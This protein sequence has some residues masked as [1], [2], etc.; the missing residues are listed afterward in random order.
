MTLFLSPLDKNTGAMFICYPYAYHEKLKNTFIE[1]ASYQTYC[2][3]EPDRYQTA[4]SRLLS[5]PNTRSRT[6]STISP[7]WNKQENNQGPPYCDFTENIIKDPAKHRQRKSITYAPGYPVCPQPRHDP[8][9]YRYPLETQ[10]LVPNLQKFNKHFTKSL[11]RTQ[12]QGKITL[13]ENGDISQMYTALDHGSILASLNWLR[14]LNLRFRRRC[15]VVIPKDPDQK[16]YFSNCI[17]EPG[18]GYFLSKQQI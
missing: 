3:E 17:T 12:S 4:T 5:P 15:G 6:S 7:R 10:D 11:K 2:T 16:P 9:V 14:I 18:S 13:T 1:N 8:P